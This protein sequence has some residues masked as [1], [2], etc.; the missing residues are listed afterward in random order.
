MHISV[1]WCFAS[2]AML[3]DDGQRCGPLEMDTMD[4]G[5]QVKGPVVASVHGHE[6]SVNSGLILA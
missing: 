2:V 3:S 4:T 6:F 5:W 1:R